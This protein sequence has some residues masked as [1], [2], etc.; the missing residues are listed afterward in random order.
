MNR[1][2]LVDFSNQPTTDPSQ[3]Y[4]GDR[5]N[6]YARVIHAD[7]ADKKAYA[8][9]FDNVANQEPLVADSNPRSAGIEI[10]PFN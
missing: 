4:R 7:M 1:S 8:F 10:G 2:T 6:H 3:F 5:T 9:P